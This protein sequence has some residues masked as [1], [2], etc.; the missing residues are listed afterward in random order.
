M[1]D[2]E[3]EMFGDDSEEEKP[4]NKVDKKRKGDKN[5]N[6]VKKKG[7]SDFSKSFIDDSAELSGEEEDDDDEEEEDDENENDYV[8][9]G[10]VVDE[11]DDEEEL[12]PRKPRGDLEDSDDEDDEDEDEEDDI[13][14][15][16][17]KS[18]VRKMRDVQ[19]LD[20]DDLDLINEARGIKTSRDEARERDREAEARRVR[21]QNEAELRK[22][23]FREDADDEPPS[24]AKSIRKQRRDV[25]RFDEDGMDDFIDDD[26]GD[27]DDIFASGGR[28]FD[29]EGGVSEAQLNEASE[30]F[31]ADYMDYMQE[32]DGD[33]NDGFFGGRSKYKERGVGV[34][35]GVD[36]DQSDDD[37]DD[38]LFGDDEKEALRVKRDNRALTKSER[39]RQAKLQKVKLQKA[40]LRKNFEPIQLIENFCTERDD[41]IRS[42]D[43]PERF[44]DSSKLYTGPKEDSEGFGEEEEEEAM[45]IMNKIPEIALDLMYTPPGDFEKRRKEIMSSIIYSL[46]YIHRDKFEPAFIKRY[47]A[48]M[49]TAEVVRNNLYVIMD[50]DLEWDR[51]TSTRS[52]VETMFSGIVSTIRSFELVGVEESIVNKLQKSLETAQAKLDL[53][54]QDEKDLLDQLSQFANDEDDNDDLFDENDV[55]VIHVCHGFKV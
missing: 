41:E 13:G 1:S 34:D 7:K 19:V 9:D 48:D 18:R 26:I 33:D 39:K 31:G 36:S 4:R 52:N 32:E 40:E 28:D 21:A 30:I 8:K 16:K 11:D 14:R 20:D 25:E 38:D 6:S 2:E 15:R 50:E 49:V 47:R 5:V 42:R 35:Y 29:E 17:K 46:R 51:L 23:L 55:S 22:G 37:D 3:G 44:F 10:F 45:W 54:I 53:T 12:R 43:L 24:Q 27:Q